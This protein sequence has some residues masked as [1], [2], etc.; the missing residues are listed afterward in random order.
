MNRLLVRVSS[1]FLALA[2]AASV[3]A[4]ARAQTGARTNFWFAGTQLIFDHATPDQLAAAIGSV[5]RPGSTN[6]PS[7][8]PGASV[9]LAEPA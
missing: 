7:R 1:L 8:S 2:L 3:L 9:L 4:P 5:S 6:H